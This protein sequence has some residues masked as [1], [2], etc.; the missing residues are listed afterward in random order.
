MVNIIDLENFYLRFIDFKKFLI[1]DIKFSIYNNFIV[2]SIYACYNI[3]G[4]GS[5][6]IKN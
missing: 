3:R 6:W 4:A 1:N 2:N 5:I